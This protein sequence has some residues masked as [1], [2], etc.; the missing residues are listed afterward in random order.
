MRCARVL[1]Y[2][3]GSPSIPIYL[4]DLS[5]IQYIYPLIIVIWRQNSRVEEV[6]SEGGGQLL[7]HRGLPGA[8]H[9]HKEEAG[10]VQTSAVSA[11]TSSALAGTSPP[12]RRAVRTLLLRKA[13]FFLAQ[14]AAVTVTPRSHGDSG[15]R[16]GRPRRRAPEP[17]LGQH[18]WKTTRWKTS[19]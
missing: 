1:C 4:S 5:L 8:H 19:T 2:G 11:A 12:A 6:V 15:R 10:A 14:P 18:S 3:Y 7:A 16:R 17:R 13:F 9:A